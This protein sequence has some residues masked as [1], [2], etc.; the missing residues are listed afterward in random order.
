MNKNIRSPNPVSNSAK[1]SLKISK[2]ALKTHSFPK[3][4]TI[5][6]SRELYIEMREQIVAQAELFLG[7]F[8]HDYYNPSVEGMNFNFF[9][10]WLDMYPFTR[11]IVRE[12]F[13]PRVWSLYV[14]YA[15]KQ[16]ILPMLPNENGDNNNT[17]AEQAVPNTNSL[18]RA[19]A[20]SGT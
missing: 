19:S 18:N 17:T 3:N 5:L 2:E 12:M 8:A 1:R 7:H 15:V 20:I 16:I 11:S 9:K 4:L 14:G 13:M 10:Q 6:S